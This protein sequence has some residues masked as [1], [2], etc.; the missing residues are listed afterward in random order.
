MEKNLEVDGTRIRMVQ[1][2]KVHRFRAVGGTE[3]V[4]LS[5][6]KVIA[7][8]A[9]HFGIVFNDQHIRHGTITPE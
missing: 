8:A 7:E 6:D 2:G 1:R 4:V 3:D 9:L 5:R